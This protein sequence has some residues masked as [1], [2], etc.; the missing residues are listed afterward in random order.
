MS[1]GEPSV[2]DPDANLVQKEYNRQTM[3]ENINISVERGK[4]VI[5]DENLV[6]I[7]NEKLIQNPNV[8]VNSKIADSVMSKKRKFKKGDSIS[9]SARRFTQSMETIETHATVQQQKVTLLVEI[10]SKD[11]ITFPDHNSIENDKHGENKVEE[12]DHMVNECSG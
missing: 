7:C 9:N 6:E 11:E 1:N 10:G 12:N 4:H 2:P 8:V 5:I 3:L